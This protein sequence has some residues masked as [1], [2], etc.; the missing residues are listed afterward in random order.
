MWNLLSFCFKCKVLVLFT[1]LL[2]ICSRDN[3]FSQNFHLHSL[4]VISMIYPWVQS[5]PFFTMMCAER[6]L[7][8]IFLKKLGASSKKMWCKNPSICNIIKN[9]NCFAVPRPWQFIGQCFKEVMSVW[10][11]PPSETFGHMSK[12]TDLF[13]ACAQVTERFLSFCSNWN[14]SES[15]ALFFLKIPE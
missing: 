6:K 12:S 8:I 15:Q 5:L 13:H 2:T 4:V 9:Q 3:F 7:W 11:M 1:L 14:P 10:E